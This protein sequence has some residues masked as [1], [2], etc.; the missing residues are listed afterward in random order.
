MQYVD[1]SSAFY[2]DIQRYYE[3]KIGELFLKITKDAG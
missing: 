1:V 3:S 2:P